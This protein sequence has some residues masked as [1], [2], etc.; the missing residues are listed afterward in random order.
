MLRVMQVLSF[1]RLVTVL[2]VLAL[3]LAG[4][5]TA[6]VAAAAPCDGRSMAVSAE[7][8]EVPCA[9]QDMPADPEKSPD[10]AACFAK[11]PAP[12]LARGPGPAF[13]PCVQLPAQGR[14]HSAL[15]GI[16]VA[17]PLE[18]PRA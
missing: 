11:C 9:G 13:L 15:A 3:L 8:G 6:F 1:R 5:A 14:R 18:P 10:A 17:P 16:G 4:F 12:L 2:S 7:V